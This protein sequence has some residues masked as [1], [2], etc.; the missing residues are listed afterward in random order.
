MPLSDWLRAQI[1]VEFTRALLAF[2]DPSPPDYVAL[3]LERSYRPAVSELIDHYLAYNPT[4]NREL[5]LLQLFDWI[6]SARVRAVA[7][8]ARIK[9]R[10]TFHYRL[11]NAHIQRPDWSLA[12]EWNRWCK[13]EHLAA[14][15]DRLEEAAT[16]YRQ[17]LSR[18][19]PEPW[20][21]KVSRYIGVS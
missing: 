14:D 16:A 8:D 15:R 21:Q 7:G 20:E 5:D 19:I 2:A 9:P 10:P 17:N 18:F 3:V 11:P 13:V 6:D 12:A 4:R 1:Q